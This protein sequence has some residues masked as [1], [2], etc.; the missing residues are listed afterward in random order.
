MKTEAEHHQL[1][2]IRRALDE[3]AQDVDAAIAARLVQARE[4]ALSGMR[5]QSGL[6]LAGHHGNLGH[7]FAPRRRMAFAFLGLMLGVV[8]AY[9]Y[10]NPLDQGD[11]RSDEVAE[12]DSAL[13]ADELPVDAYAD[14]GFQA[15]LDRTSASQSSP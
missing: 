9:Y 6:R 3:G 11:D 5:R 14:Q 10:W 4:I 1:Q 13:L 7:S 15:W 8:G 2:A 12:V